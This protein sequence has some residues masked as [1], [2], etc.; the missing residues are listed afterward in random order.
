[1]PKRQACDILGHSG[2]VALDLELE[3][4]N[5]RAEPILRTD[6][7]LCPPCPHSCSVPPPPPPGSCERHQ[8]AP[9]SLT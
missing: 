5:A 8:H 9:S 2:D 3:A 1:M 7:R 6:V 4:L